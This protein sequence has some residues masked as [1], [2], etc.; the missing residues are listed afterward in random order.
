MSEE[1]KITNATTETNEVEVV[2]N[3]EK[4]GFLAKAKAGFEKY[5]KKA[6]IVVS[7]VV[8]GGIGYALGRKANRDS[9]YDHDDLV[10][11]VAEEICSSVDPEE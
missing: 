7:A 11:V 5:G 8:I 10:E 4:K 9:D 3:E 1:T 2:E 6:V